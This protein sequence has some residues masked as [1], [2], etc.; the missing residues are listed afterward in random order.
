M[1][2]TDIKGIKGIMVRTADVRGKARL[3]VISTAPRPSA[4]IDEDGTSGCRDD[5]KIALFETMNA[6]LASEGR[7]TIE[8]FCMSKWVVKKIEATNVSWDR[9][10][11][12]YA[13]FEEDCIVRSVC[14]F[15]YTT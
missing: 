7:K 14:I 5:W 10:S 2:I 11:G 8:A 9:H 12:T 6:V 13:L 15:L 1:G 4:I 3:E